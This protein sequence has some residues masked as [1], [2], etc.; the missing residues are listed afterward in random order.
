MTTQPN[1]PIVVGVDGSDTAAAAIRWAAAEAAR[2]HAP[3]QLINAIDI[4]I[5]YGP[6]LG[7]V[8]IDPTPYRHEGAEIV[9]AAIRTATKAAA[10]ID[11]IEAAGEVTDGAPI[12]ILIHRAETARMLVVGTRGLGAFRRG[13]LG[14]VSTSVARHASCPVA[15]IPETSKHPTEGPVVVGVDGSECSTRA[16]EIAFDEASR[17][18][19]DLTAVLTWSEFNRFIP[20]AEMQIEAEGLL[21]ESLAGYTEKY[22]D[23]TVRRIVAE[24]SPTR[25]LLEESEHAQLIVVG[26]HGRGGFA[27]MTLG[28]VSQAVLHATEIPLIIAR[29]TTEKP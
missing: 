3:L 19:T 15:I 20:R 29:S 28:S 9:S 2:N 21:A 17:R 13:L 10:P 14:S 23:V 1:S 27:G 12:P 5:D 4:P 7:V 16:V 22:P 18:G 8:P 26:S 25:R 6:G 24:A 11:M